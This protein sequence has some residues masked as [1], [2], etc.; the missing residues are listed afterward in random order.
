MIELSLWLRM[1]L[2]RF[3][4]VSERKNSFRICMMLQVELQKVLVTRKGLDTYLHCSTLRM[5]L[6]FLVEI[7]HHNQVICFDDDRSMS[8]KYL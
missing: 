4:C 3:S 5:M 8:T 6:Y 7:S 1:L 2:T